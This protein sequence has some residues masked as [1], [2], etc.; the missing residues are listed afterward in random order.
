MV[1]NI[2]MVLK[3]TIIHI[4]ICIFTQKTWWFHISRFSGEFHEDAWNRW[5]AGEFPPLELRN[6]PWRS[7]SGYQLAQQN[8]S[9]FFPVA[10]GTHQQQTQQGV[11]TP[12]SIEMTKW[13]M[14][15]LGPMV[16]GFNGIFFHLHPWCYFV[17]MW[18]TF[19]KWVFPKNGGTP[20]F[21]PQNDHF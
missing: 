17:E 20:H 13:S 2:Q 6:P 10:Q 15:K 11:T 16:S 18:P 7:N 12:W 9:D 19:T 8:S 4:Y 14:K 5:I 3:S 21:T 1:S